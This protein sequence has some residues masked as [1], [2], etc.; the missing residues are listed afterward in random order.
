[1]NANVL[2]IKRIE[3]NWNR[4]YSK[5]PDFRPSPGV[6]VEISIH[7]DTEQI[8]ASHVDKIRQR[9]VKTSNWNFRSVLQTEVVVFRA[10]H[11]LIITA[12]RVRFQGVSGLV[13][14]RRIEL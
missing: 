6:S 11:F 2:I 7:R 5:S 9:F 12:E 13:E 3:L 1:M 10:V 4:T 8:G 14:T